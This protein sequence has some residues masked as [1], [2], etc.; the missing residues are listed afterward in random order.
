MDDSGAGWRP[1]ARKQ[2]AR[3]VPQPDE[4]V[5]G[6]L[7]LSWDIDGSMRVEECGP[8]V[9]FSASWL[10]E[11]DAFPTERLSIGRPANGCIAGSVLRVNADNRKVVYVIT[12]EIIKGTSA[13]VGRWP[14]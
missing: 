11:I 4:E 6:T 5:S 8:A 2:A 1:E 10:E 13:W 3:L 14:D 12:D 7:A 9:A